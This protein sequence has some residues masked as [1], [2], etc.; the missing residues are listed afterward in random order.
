[1]R[2]DARVDHAHGDLVALDLLHLAERRLDRALHVGLDDEVELADAAGLDRVEQVL[3]RD[4]LLAARE[5]LGA[6]ALRALLGLLARR[7][8]GVD[9]ARALAGDGRMVEAEDLDG[10]GRAGVLEPRRRC[11]RTSRAPC[12]RRL[13]RRPRT[14]GCIVPRWTSSVATGPRPMSRRDSMIEPRRVGLR[15]GLQL[16]HVGLQQQHLEQARETGL[17]ACGDV[18][19]DRLAA[20]LLGLQPVRSSAPGARARGWRRAGRS[21]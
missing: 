3:E 7:P 12:P 16:E 14:P 20:P 11:R 9:D 13:R 21:C 5:R 2:A 15:V 8:L 17:L 1:M 10:H 19:E 4:R 6:Q 18:D